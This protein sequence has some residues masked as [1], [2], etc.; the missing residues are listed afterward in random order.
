MSDDRSAFL[1]AIEN[2]PKNYGHRYVYADWLDEQGEHEEADRQRKFEASEKWLQEFAKGDE[3]FSFSSQYEQDEEPK[4]DPDDGY[5]YCCAYHQFLRF[6][7][8][9]EDGSITEGF[10]LGFDTPYGW[11][12]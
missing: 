9:H 5:W 10:Y 7:E 2:E 1:E 12:N 8:A 3:E 6:L 11:N 4:C